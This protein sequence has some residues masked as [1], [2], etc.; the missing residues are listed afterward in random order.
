MS[1]FSKI[2]ANHRH[3]NVLEKA[4]YSLLREAYISP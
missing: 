3:G 2:N 1:V 4:C